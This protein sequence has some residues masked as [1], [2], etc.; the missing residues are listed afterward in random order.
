MT[1]VMAI[2]PDEEVAETV[3]SQLSDLNIDDLDWRLIH[4]GEDDERLFPVLGWPL[5]GG[6]GG[7]ASAAGSGGPI[8]AAIR[9]GYPEDEDMR[10]EG[11]KDDDAEFYGQSVQHGGIAI[12]VDTPSKYVDDVRRVLEKADAEQVTTQ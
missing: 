2:L 1:K 10:D 3:T 6:S 8:G 9:T 12:V 5:G 7:S 4:P 11:A